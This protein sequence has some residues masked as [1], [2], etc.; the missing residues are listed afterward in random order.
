MELERTT[1]CCHASFPPEEETD[2]PESLFSICDIEKEISR[3]ILSIYNNQF[4]HI[5]TPI[6]LSQ[7]K[8]SLFPEELKDYYMEDMLSS[9]ELNPLY[10]FR[11]TFPLTL[12]RTVW[13]N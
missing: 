13:K 9:G 3:D 4:I 6:T 7:E 11:V 12:L 8:A 1:P 10:W 2:E 5:T